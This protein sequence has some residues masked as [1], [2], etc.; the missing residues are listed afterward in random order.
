MAQKSNT[1]KGFDISKYQ[2]VTS[3]ERVTVRIEETGDEFEVTIKPMSWSKRNQLISRCLKFTSNGGTNF[4]A[5]VYVRESLK[6]M[7]IDAP[8]GR[9]TEAFLMSIDQRLGSALETLVPQAFSGDSNKEGGIDSI[10]KE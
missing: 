10:K 7:I 8:W 3:D 9:T 1:T 5:D 6:E 2:T 4:E